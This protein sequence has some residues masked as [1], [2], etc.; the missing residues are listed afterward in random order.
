MP[1]KLLIEGEDIVLSMRTHAKALI[2]PAVVIIVLAG[3]GSYLTALVASGSGEGT[4]V[5]GAVI[6]I[7]VA[8]ALAI[9]VWAVIPFLRWLT[10]EYTVTTRRVLLTSGLLTR[11]GRAIPLSRVND[12]TFEKGLLDRLLGCGTLVVSDAT[13]QSGMRLHDVPQVESVHRR[14]TDLIFGGSDGLDDDGSRTP[15]GR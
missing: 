15:G 4:V 9:V 13:E 5:R 7:W 11:T 8:A 14:L 10:T 6:G 1:R 12:V 3:I 2:L